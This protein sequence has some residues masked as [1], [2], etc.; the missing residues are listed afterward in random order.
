MNL[1]PETAGPNC[2]NGGTRLDVGTDEDNSGLL[3]EQEIEQT[4]YICDGGFMNTTLLTSISPP[5]PIMN[6]DAGGR[7]IRHGLDNGDG[8]GFEA[9]G[10]LEP[11]EVDATIL[12]ALDMFLMTRTSELFV[13]STIHQITQ[14]R[15]NSRPWIKRS[16]SL[17]M[18][19][20]MVMALEK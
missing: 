8:G 11:G 10:N 5:P 7:M 13:T 12:S 15:L 4:Q 18:M 1:Y 16:I 20:Y 9:N 2:A 6:C 3:E 14:H 17:Q 19:G